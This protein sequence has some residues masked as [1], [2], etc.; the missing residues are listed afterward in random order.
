VI[1]LEK[2]Y[3]IWQVKIGWRE[4]NEKL[5]TD[6]NPFE[7]LLELLKPNSESMKLY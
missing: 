3:E 4:I 2:N 1:K 6:G 5:K 7:M